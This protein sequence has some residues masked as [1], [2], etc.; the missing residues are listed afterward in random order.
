ML[1][2]ATHGKPLRMC[3]SDGQWVGCGH[4]QSLPKKDRPLY[5]YLP[6]GLAIRKLCQALVQR[7]QVDDEMVEMVIQACQRSAQEAQLGDGRPIEDLTSEAGRLARQIQFILDNPGETDADRLESAQKLRSLRSERASRLA[8][9]AAAKDALDQP[10]RIPSPEEVRQLLNNF[11][12]I[13]CEV[14]EGRDMKQ[15]ACARGIIEMLTGGQIEIEQMGERR[16]G[17]G[18]LRGRFKLRLLETTLS[19]LVGLNGT[20]DE[21]D[22][23]EVIV[24]FRE[25]LIA[26]R[27][28]D[29][30]KRLYDEG[31][32]VTAIGERLG[33][34]R[35]QVTDALRI[36]HERHD[37]PVPLDGR[38]RR[39][40][41]KQ[42]NLKPP[43]F[44]E[45]ADQAKVLLDQKLH[46][47]EIASR[48]H[49]DRGTIRSALRYW[50]KSHGQQMPDG[51]Q[52]RKELGLR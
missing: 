30:V 11:A 47:W 35:H 27:H 10:I 20:S 41:V 14:G 48:L 25:D 34:D 45:I 37:L 13:L 39:G 24:D 32:L 40:L 9:V 52:R 21:S 51:R 19:K 46:L 17:R 8:A 2:C 4:C 12:D 38:V 29:D 49:R 16:R 28:A 5:S 43:V 7:I 22:M 50:F 44:Q 36:W 15:G 33:I 1:I 26:E 31:L 23:P 18:W 6:R 42:K 3:G